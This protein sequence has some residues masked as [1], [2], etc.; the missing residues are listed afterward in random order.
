MEKIKLAIY[1]F[2][3]GR[4]GSDTLNKVMLTIALVLILMNTFLFNNGIVTILTYV[5]L[6]LILFRSFSRNIYKRQLENRKF[7][8]LFQPITNRVNIFK[9][10]RNDKTHRYYTCPK[11]KQNVRVPKGLGKIEIKCPRCSQKFKKRT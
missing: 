3:R 1:Q 5:V 11:C 4:Y 10:Q 8:R 2:M 9:K 6:F 7:L